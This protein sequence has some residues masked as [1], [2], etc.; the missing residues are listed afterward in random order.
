MSLETQIMQDI[1]EAMFSKNSLK[2][3]V[4]RSIKSE[5]LLV[6]TERE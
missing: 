4:F 5:I 6:K 2:L 3:E 1:K